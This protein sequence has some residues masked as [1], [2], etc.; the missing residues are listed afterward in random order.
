VDGV[1]YIGLMPALKFTQQE[2]K[3]RRAQREG[4]GS[5]LIRASVEVVRHLRGLAGK[6]Q[7]PV[8]VASEHLIAT[9]SQEVRVLHAIGQSGSMCYEMPHEAAEVM[10]ALVS[11]GKW[12][13]TGH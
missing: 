2:L 3:H 13:I 5:A 9:A 6:Y 8:V 7:K 4:W 11:Y 10:A 1:I 12:V